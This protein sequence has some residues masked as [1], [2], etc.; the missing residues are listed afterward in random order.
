MEYHFNT[1]IIGGGPSG[2]SCGITLLKHGHDC[3]IVERSTFPRVK[4]CAGLFTHKSQE[5]LKSILGPNVYTEVMR[6]SLMS[7]ES[8]F[9]LYKGMQPLVSC[10]LQKEDNQPTSLR[11]TDCRIS[12]VNR[13][14]LDDLLVKNFVSL[15]GILL[16]N[17]AVK[18][19]DFAKKTAILASGRTITYEHLVAADGAN[20]ITERALAAYD[21]TFVKKDKSALCIEINVDKD[22]VDVTG[23]NIYFDIVKGSYA[24]AF[25]KGEKVC[26]GLVKLPWQENTDVQH[27][28]L[29]FCSRLGVRNMEKY[30]LRGAMLPFGNIMPRPVWN[31]NVFFV[32]DAAGLVEPLTGEGIYYA[33]QSGQYAGESIVNGGTDSYIDKVAYLHGLIKKGRYYQ[34]LLEMKLPSRFFFRHAP[35]NGR[36]ISYFYLTQIEHATLDPFWKIIWKYKRKK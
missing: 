26:I 10:N 28:M 36:F 11:Y 17:D 9:S 13:P 34:S 32:G 21:K 22:D 1:L 33:L 25:A 7:Q 19:I 3:C 23:V 30:P 15:G 27:T 8:V 16:D 12:L 20:S 14:V 6:K 31:D 24:W 18:D 5:C 29:D 2:S 4:L 35:R